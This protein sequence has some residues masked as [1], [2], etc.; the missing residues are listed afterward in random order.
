LV[1][2][3]AVVKEANK[4]IY[5]KIDFYEALKEKKEAYILKD[6]KKIWFN[7]KEKKV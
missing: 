2:D 6:G 4:I 3:G 5:L 1:I 7:G